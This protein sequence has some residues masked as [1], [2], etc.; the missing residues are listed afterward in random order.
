MTLKTWD[1]TEKAIARRLPG[2]QPR[3]QQQTLARA[4]EGAL[5]NGSSLLAQ[6][7]CGTGKSIGGMVPAILHALS[8]GE[9]IIIATA[10]KALQE[11]Y[12]NSDVPFLQQ[13]FAE[14]GRPFT[15]ALLKGRSNYICAARTKGEEAE[16]LPFLKPLLDEL[17]AN[18]NHSGDREHFATV[19]EDREWAQVS[20][21]ANDCPGKRDCPFGQR[22]FA[23]KAKEEAKQANVVVTNTAFLLM[24]AVVRKMTKD[25][26]QGPVE[27]LGPYGTALYDEAHEIGE[28]AQ[29]ALGFDFT[30]RGMADWATRC[31]TFC[32]LQSKDISASTT[33]F[34]NALEAL[35]RVL[36][37]LDGK[38]LS[39]AWMAENFE[40]FAD[41]LDTVREIREAVFETNIQRDFDAQQAKLKMLLTRGDSIDSRLTW[42]MVAG[43][44]ELVRWI[45]KT[46]SRR[47]EQSWKLCASPVDVAPFLEEMLWG[48]ESGKNAIL[49]SA[50]L[51]AGK[52][53]NGTADFTYL[54]RTLGLK[55]AD[56][57]DVGTP[58]DFPNQALMF[59]PDRNTPSP[60]DR[61][62]WMNY[63]MATTLQAIEASQ[64]GALLLYTSRTAMEDA[65]RAL[66]D[67]LEMMGFTAL[68]QGNQEPGR[69]F[70]NKELARRF[71]EDHNS[72]LFALKSFFV[73]VD[74][75]GDACRLV[76]VDKLPFPV[77][78]DPIYAARE[79]A[80]R[81]ANRHP[82]DS[83]AI[84]IMTLT[85]E[86]AIGRLIRRVSDTGV[87]MILDSRLS[88][89][90][91]GR[92]I[93]HNLPNFPVT[94]LMSDVRA[95]FAR[96]FGT[97]A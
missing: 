68:M 78:S 8:T 47:G 57:L 11:Q 13:V 3:P 43:D 36:L 40:P 66:R 65:Y 12:W 75:P 19:V 76:I 6:A 53:P 23:E 81:D 50:T 14:E 22:C 25:R 80:E 16:G 56:A 18:P 63:S 7:G 69:Q 93:V 90:G 21:G 89:T 41:L 52:T 72:V 35:E 91:Y 10:T 9:R 92:K 84:P 38:T 64:G 60:K 28:Y 27:L 79:Q 26:E 71:K 45:E 97:A 32:A 74:V 67:S 88:S 34:A 83:L 55:S 58:F 94:T 44:G 5:A 86:Q 4:I 42:L 17:E 30:A 29:G 48:P 24:D 70:S 87:V 39:Q 15:A 61:G 31:N 77:P 62:A 54:R 82:F 33:A 20:T 1:D 96:K 49:M 51:A 73:G 46:V 2:Y 95:F 85:L 37:P 59:V